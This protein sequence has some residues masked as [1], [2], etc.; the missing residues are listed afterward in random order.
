MPRMLGPCR[1]RQQLSPVSGAQRGCAR[2]DT[3][4]PAAWPPVHLRWQPSLALPPPALTACDCFCP[5]GWLMGHWTDERALAF[6]TYKLF[7]CH[8]PEIFEGVACPWNRSHAAAAH[9]FKNPV[10]LSSVRSQVGVRPCAG[11]P[12]CS[13]ASNPAPCG[14]RA[15]PPHQR[16]PC[17]A[18]PCKCRPPVQHAALY[19]TQLGASRAG[20]LGS[21]ADLFALFGFGVRDGQRRYFTYSL[22]PDR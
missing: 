17:V 10:M 20:V 12:G 7:L 3:L 8:V 11:V 1:F 5:P 4:L 19:A 6:S 16:R 15:L 14:T 13:A 22:L 18:V 2:L 9:I 21:P